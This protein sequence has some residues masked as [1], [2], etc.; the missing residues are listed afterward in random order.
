MNKLISYCGLDCE[1]CQARIATINDDNK[2]RKEVAEEWSKLNGVLI[3][4]EDI[5][6]VGCKVDGIKFSF[7]EKLCPIRKCALE[8]K[9]E[10]CGKCPELLSCE[11]IQMIISSNKDAL[12]RLNS[13]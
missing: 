2:L 9:L 7:C 13:K 12:D 4:P 1:N 6:C 8:K 3:K 11:K 10:N 5:N